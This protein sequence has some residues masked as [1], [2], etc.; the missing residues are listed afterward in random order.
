MERMFKEL[1][2]EISK[3][4]DAFHEKKKIRLHITRL[5]IQEAG[6]IIERF[7]EEEIKDLSIAIDQL[8]EIYEEELC[9]NLKD[10]KSPSS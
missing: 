4:I 9:E 1:I 6:H 3:G 5:V 8:K 2:D 10:S 7:C